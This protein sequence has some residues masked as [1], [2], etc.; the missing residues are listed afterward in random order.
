MV[1]RPNRPKKSKS[2]GFNYTPPSADSIK[3]RATQRGGRF[4]TIFKQGFDSWWPQDGDNQIRILP[5]LPGEEHYAYEVWVHRFVGSDESTYLCPR[6]NK[7][8]KTG[9][10]MGKPCPIC[11]AVKAMKAEGDAEDAKKIDAT[12][13]FVCWMIDRDADEPMAQLWAMSWTQDKELAALQYNSRTGKTLLIA[14]PEE[15]FD[16]QIKKS[17]KGIKTKYQLAIDREETPID[18]DDAVVA[19]LAEY[20]RENPI[21]STLKFYDADYLEGIVSGTAE[22][23]DEDLDDK[24]SKKGRRARDEDE[25]TE[26]EE[27][28]DE[29]PRRGRRSRDEE[30]TEDEEDEDEEKPR[31]GGIKRRKM[32]KPAED[33]DESEDDG[34]TQDDDED[35][36]PRR[37]K[38]RR[39]RDEDTEEEED[40]EKPRSRRRSKPSDEE[41]DEDNEQTEDEED[42]KPRRGKS[43]R[44]V[45]RARDEEDDDGETEDDDGEDEK[46]RKPF[47][48]RRR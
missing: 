11:D 37:G 29:K 41:E 5:P 10:P 18:E 30:E 9:Q 46:P 33:E 7:S 19:E 38:Y 22:N 4:E 14:H 23:E 42:E 21:P 15:G 39:S 8:P 26:D 28:E 36:K 45:R 12:Q 32:R 25:E 24:K 34:E 17:G 44:P 2:K 31:R 16:V 27:D 40:E 48:R 20:C 3:K 13:Q 47:R 35:E 1:N 6:K 43:R